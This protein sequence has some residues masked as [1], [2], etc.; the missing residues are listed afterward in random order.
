MR[1]NEH[2]ADRWL[3]DSRYEKRYNREIPPP[4]PFMSLV[5][6]MW[7]MFF[8]AVA[9]VATVYGLPAVQAVCS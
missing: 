5:K 4:A 6:V 1:R 7:V 8:V 9:T 3:S 2:D